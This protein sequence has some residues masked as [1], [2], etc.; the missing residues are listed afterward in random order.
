MS[1][2]HGDGRMTHFA[3]YDVNTLWQE[4]NIKNIK[5]D[6]PTGWTC[7]KNQSKKTV[8]QAAGAQ[9]KDDDSDRKAGKS[10]VSDRPTVSPPGPNTEAVICHTGP[11]LALITACSRETWRVGTLSP[12]LPSHITH[13]S[14]PARVPV[15]RFYRCVHLYF[16]LF[17]RVAAPPKP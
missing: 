13:Q 9:T 7:K 15:R 10:G 2:R 16:N 11:P 12:D 5:D 17:P 14:L 8:V 3:G 6:Y 1:G 4:A